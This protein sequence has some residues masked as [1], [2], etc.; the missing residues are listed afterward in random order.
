MTNARSSSGISVRST[1]PNSI[2]SLPRPEPVRV[3]GS[4]QDDNEQ[5]DNFS[6]PPH[7]SESYNR[8]AASDCRRPATKV[9]VQY[10]RDNSIGSSRV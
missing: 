8:R 9:H 6:L 10:D 4:S 7:L 5:D 2:P 3:A 1:V